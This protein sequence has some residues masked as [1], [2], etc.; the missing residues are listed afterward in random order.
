M[1]AQGGAAF[2]AAELDEVIAQA[3]AAPDRYAAEVL[4]SDLL[5]VGLYLLPAGATDDQ[6][7][8]GEDEVYYVVRGRAVLRVGVEDHPVQTGTLLFVPAMAVHFF[9]D[10]SEELVLVVFWAPPE[11]SVQADRPA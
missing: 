9:H 2:Q 3:R 11:G 10:I 6:E 1:K 7:P 4:R 8:H 5:S